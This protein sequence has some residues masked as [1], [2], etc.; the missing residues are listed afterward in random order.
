MDSSTLE[1]LFQ[2]YAR[3]ER[4]GPGS[5]ATTRRALDRLGP[6][7]PCPQI[8]DFGCGAGPASLVLAEATD[9]HVTAVDIYRPYLDT[10]GH[11]AARRG[12]KV[13][14]LCADMIDPPL[15]DGSFDLVWSEGAIYL[16]GFE[17]GLRR[18]KRLLRRGGFV[19]VSEVTW[20]T[21]DPPPG[22]AEFWQTAYPAITTVEENIRTM[23]RVGFVP[24]EPFVLPPEDWSENFY[25]PLQEELVRFRAEFAGDERVQAVADSEQREIDLW[26]AYGESYGY[27]FYLGKLADGDGGD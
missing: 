20:L 12:L 8:V 17:S 27:V 3:L 14:T 10:L 19:A 21:P 26:Q 9:G 11:E 13:T 18:W 5:V 24:L 1:L 6:L 16:A 7:P 23:Q 25:R 22:A 15:A 2:F 4:K